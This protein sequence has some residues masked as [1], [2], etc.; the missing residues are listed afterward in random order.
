MQMSRYEITYA[1][2]KVPGFCSISVNKFEDIRGSF[3]RFY[4][5]DE[6]NKLFD[7]NFNIKQIN[8]SK[9]SKRGTFRGFHYQKHPMGE[10]KILT[11]LCGSFLD[12][13]VDMR[14]ELQTYLNYDCIE[15]DSVAG[16]IV[17]IPR[18]CG[19]AIL[20]KEDD[21]IAVYLSDQ[22][23]SPE[24][25][26]GIAISDPLIGIAE[27]IINQVKEI[28]DKDRSWAKLNG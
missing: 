3:H 12:I 14:K 15:F 21:S 27:T 7:E 13:V 28:S 4:C 1:S 8:I 25:E 9:S 2:K 18:G 24:H 20:S 10:R 11:S 6:L 19:H 16:N 17:H 22:F 26:E 5:E 23:Y